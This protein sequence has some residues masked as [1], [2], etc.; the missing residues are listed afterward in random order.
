MV[1]DGHQVVGWSPNLVS[2]IRT[3]TLTDVVSFKLI[4][5]ILWKKTWWRHGGDTVE[6][7]CLET[8]N[9]VATDP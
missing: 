1:T 7:Q 4:W 2:M 8:Y 9:L 3:S 6:T 5:A